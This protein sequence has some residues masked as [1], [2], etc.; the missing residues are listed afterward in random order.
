[1][2]PTP[3]TS[4]LPTETLILVPEALSLTPYK[5]VPDF[6]VRINS[7]LLRALYL[8]FYYS[9]YSSLTFMIVVIYVSASPT[10]AGSSL[11][12]EPCQFCALSPAG[13]Y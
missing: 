13:G 5:A 1:M 10:G 8:N 12:A 4:A 7:S 2:Q 11:R 6:P 9:N 3:S